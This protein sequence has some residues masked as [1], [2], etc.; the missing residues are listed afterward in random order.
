[1][2]KEENDKIKFL[3]LLCN[4]DEDERVLRGAAGALAMMTYDKVICHKIVSVS[5]F[6]LIQPKEESL[7]V[8]VTLPY[9]EIGG[10][11]FSLIFHSVIPWFP[12]T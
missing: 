5:T 12:G 7:E 10:N 9:L 6:T 11:R 4:E 3:V 2:H 8:L 1:M